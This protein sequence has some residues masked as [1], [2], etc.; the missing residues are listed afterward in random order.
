MVKTNKRRVP[1]THCGLKFKGGQGLSLHM[2]LHCRQKPTAADD[3]APCQTDE[4]GAVT[5]DETAARDLVPFDGHP[6]DVQESIQ[7]FLRWMRGKLLF[8]GRTMNANNCARILHVWQ[9]FVADHPSFFVDTFNYKPDGK[10]GQRGK[11]FA[12]FRDEIL[13]AGLR[14]GH[15]RSEVEVG[16]STLQERHV[17][18]IA[19]RS[20][21]QA[22][23]R[24]IEGWELASA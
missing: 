4:V 6:P 19:V 10:P 7:L 18:R 5:T 11:M 20:D 14:F 3:I 16:L 1:C 9:S 8:T 21:G 2:R 22:S 23:V 12:L 13:P 24:S 17:K 15:V